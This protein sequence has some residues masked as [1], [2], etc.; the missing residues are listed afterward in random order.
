M[1]D[2][3]SRKTIIGTVVSD[4]MDKAITVQWEVRKIHP[5]YKKFITWH[6]KLKAR[7]NRNEAA[8]GDVVKIMSTRP[9]SKKINWRLVE[10]IEK[11]QRG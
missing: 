9:L 11:A 3:V 7:D 1:K 8:T 2:D 10:I 6:K 5:F 4:R